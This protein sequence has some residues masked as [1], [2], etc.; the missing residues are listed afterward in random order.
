MNRLLV[1][2]ATHP[3]KLDDLVTDLGRSW[4]EHANA[5]IGTRF[6]QRGVARLNIIK[7]SEPFDS[8]ECGFPSPADMEQR[9]RT[10]LGEDDRLLRFPEG[11]ESPLGNRM[12]SLTIPG[13]MARGVAPEAE[14]EHIVWKDG[15]ITFSMGSCRYH[16]D[17]FGLRRIDA[18]PD[19]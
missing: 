13:W 1:E 5:V 7:R 16:Y 18:Q 9:I 10:R 6:A 8:I 17:R 14:A 19:D 4:Q 12:T 11:P 2:G 15:S 3:Q